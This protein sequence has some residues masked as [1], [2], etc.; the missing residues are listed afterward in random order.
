MATSL[1]KAPLKVSIME[2]YTLNGREHFV[3]HS[4]QYDDIME[5]ATRIVSCPSG[6]TSL[7]TLGT[8]PAAGT[9][10]QSTTRYIRITNLESP[11]TDA[12]TINVSVVGTTAALIASYP[13]TPGSS[14]ML[15]DLTNILQIQVVN[16]N[17]AAVD[18]EG[19]VAAAYVTP[20]AS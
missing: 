17:A 8:A 14:F 3:E 7:Y 2:T 15:T 5:T 1:K 6:T 11:G 20:P 16:G 12:L 19:F 13:V 4:V 10:V 18:V 9:L